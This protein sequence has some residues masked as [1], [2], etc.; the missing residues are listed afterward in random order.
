MINSEHIVKDSDL[1]I[2]KL[3]EFDALFLNDLFSIILLYEGILPS[4]L[5]DIVQNYKVLSD[6]EN[7][8]KLSELLESVNKSDIYK[9]RFININNSALID[10]NQISSIVLFEKYDATRMC[11]L[12]CFTINPVSDKVKQQNILDLTYEFRSLEKRNAEIENI[13][14]NFKRNLIKIY[15][16]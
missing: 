11:M 3:S 4:D 7:A 5:L 14:N 9:R 6:K 10:V 8:D 2:Q 15:E 16:N 1:E 12:Y 13:K